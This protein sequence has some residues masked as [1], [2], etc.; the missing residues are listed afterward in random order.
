MRRTSFKD[1]RAEI[2]RR[3]S[4]RLWR[5]GEIIPGEEALAAEFGA[6]RAT[7]NRALQE[8]ARAGLVERKRKSGTRVALH[9]VREARFVI[10][11]V[12]AEIEASG[13]AYAYRLISREERPV[14]EAVAARL[15][16]AAGAAGLHVACLHAA[17]GRPYQYE[18]RWI[19]LDTVPA[20]G[21]E[22]FDAVGPNE[23]LVANAPFSQARFGFAAAIATPVEARM[24][25]LEPG[26]A[27]FVAERVTWLSGRSITLVRMVHPP[28]HTMVMD[29]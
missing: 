23:W 10:P 26:A 4:M 3:I 18:D 21:G 5:P 24:L 20:A 2:E 8:L 15:G 6:A 17:D 12:R 11:L 7:V 29:M 19:N 13:M 16:I 9:P 14:P 25:G 28:S 27:V 1:I 22:R